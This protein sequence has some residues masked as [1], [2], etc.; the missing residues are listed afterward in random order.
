MTDP[1]SAF[2]GA[3]AA[4]SLADVLLRS[5]KRL[6]VFFGELKDA[7][8]NTRLLLAELRD[9]EALFAEVR[10]YTNDFE[11]SA[12]AVEDGEVIPEIKRALDSCEV[13]L[14]GLCA[15]VDALDIKVTDSKVKRMAKKMKFVCDQENVSR[16]LPN[17]DKARGNL[18][19]A[20]LVTQ[21]RGNVSLREQQK[22]TRRDISTL[23]TSSDSHF[24]NLESIVREASRETRQ[25]LYTSI[26]ASAKELQVDIQDTI[27]TAGFV[28]HDNIS[29]LTKSVGTASSKTE[30]ALRSMQNTTTEIAE[31][32][33]TAHN[34]TQSLIISSATGT[35]EQASLRHE[36]ISRKL[37]KMRTLSRLSAKRRK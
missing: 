25:V 23:Q 16:P 8:K 19:M 33:R 3:A 18:M 21:A 14:T 2:S 12:F 1:L 37:D 20:L 5:T 28:T 7:S 36:R 34:A 22:A 29:A 17:I 10:K 6:Y 11:T 13:E 27:R 26:Q 24:G 31:H 4:V 32:S 30:D 35:Q 15:R 9:L